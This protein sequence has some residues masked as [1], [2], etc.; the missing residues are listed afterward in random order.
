M[1]SMAPL[2]VPTC[3]WKEYQG[4]YA[5]GETVL[6]RYYAAFDWQD[7]S[8]RVQ[9]GNHREL[10]ASYIESYPLSLEFIVKFSKGVQLESVD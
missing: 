6:R 9:W 3:R 10:L 5:F 7:P 2:V 4:V 8:V 1:G